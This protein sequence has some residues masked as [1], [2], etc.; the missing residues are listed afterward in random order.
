[1][2]NADLTKLFL[3]EAGLD[4]S[5][6]SVHTHKWLWW[7]NPISSTSLRLTQTGADFMT[8]TLKLQ[9]YKYRLNAEWRATSR[10]ILALERHM[11]VP[12]HFPNRKTI[13]FFAEHD[14]MMLALYGND[15]E[16]YL[17]NLAANS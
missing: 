12:F 4:T 8:N 1:M 7:M 9:S 3:Q 14:A 17:K 5:D 10:L 15:L 13:V 11:T 2:N 6:Q 16:S